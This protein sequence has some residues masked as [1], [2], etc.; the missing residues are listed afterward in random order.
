MDSTQS[1]YHYLY[2]LGKTAVNSNTPNLVRCCL[3]IFYGFPKTF[4]ICTYFPALDACFMHKC[5]AGGCHYFL[6]RYSV[7]FSTL[8]CCAIRSLMACLY[9]F[10][11]QVFQ[12]S[13]I[14]H[15]RSRLSLHLFTSHVFIVCYLVS[16]IYLARIL[17]IIFSFMVNVVPIFCSTHGVLIAAVFKF[18]EFFYILHIFACPFSSHLIVPVPPDFSIHCVLLSHSCLQKRDFSWVLIIFIVVQM[19]SPV[20]LIFRNSYG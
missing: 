12:C 6:S 15:D 13:L 17:C 11:L 2:S 3:S 9:V 4:S 5:F 18:S 19:T 20:P 10:R 14:S 8:G 16:D 1:Y 7:Y